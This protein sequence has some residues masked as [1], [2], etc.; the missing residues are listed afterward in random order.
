MIVYATRTG[1]VAYI[2]NSL[3]LPSRK[4]EDVVV[5]SEPYFLFS[6]TDGLGELPDRV[7]KFLDRHEN[8]MFLEGVIASG[9]TNFGD[10]F[11]KVADLISYEYR[12]PIIRK[13]DLR[14]TGE[15]LKHIRQQYK[16]LIEVKN[17]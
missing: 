4:I 6:Y 17:T 2:I 9:N 15:D 5:M 8:K 13:I 14:G 1:N 12:V 7:R 16:R 3:G 11:C 10:N